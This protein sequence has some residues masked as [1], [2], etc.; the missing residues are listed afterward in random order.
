MFTK[1]VQ[2]I[3][4]TGDKHIDDYT[5]IVLS[6]DTCSY[7]DVKSTIKYGRDQVKLELL[8]MA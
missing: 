1:L 4:Q 2:D 6:N 7:S 3:K 8:R 5:P